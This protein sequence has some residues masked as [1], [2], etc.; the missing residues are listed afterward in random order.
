MNEDD[1]HEGDLSTVPDP[2]P[3]VARERLHQG[4]DDVEMA[5]ASA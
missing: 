1:G 3:D 5:R 4:D 2:L